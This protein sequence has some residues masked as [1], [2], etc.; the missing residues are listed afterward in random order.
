MLSA[1]DQTTQLAKL[2]PHRVMRELYE[3]S[4]AYWRAYARELADYRPEDDSLALVANSTSGAVVWICASITY[5][6]AAAR[7]PLVFPGAPPLTVAEIGDSADPEVFMGV[8]SPVCTDWAEAM[9]RF[10]A[11]T[12]QWAATLDPN[13]PASQWPP[14]ILDLSAK[15]TSILQEN[16]GQI[17]NLGAVSQNPILNDFASLAAQYQ[18]AYVQSIPSYTPADNY[19]NSTAAELVVAVSQACLA[20]EA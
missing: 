15:T 8:R 13:V 3:Q 20:T 9:D 12:D 10:N 18:R 7:K 19:L 17:Q 6:S 1:A 14:E 5:G 16:A 11:A 2:T 4:I